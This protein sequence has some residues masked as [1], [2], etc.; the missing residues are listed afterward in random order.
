MWFSIL[1]GVICDANKTSFSHSVLPQ[2]CAVI[3]YIL[4]ALV[5]LGAFVERV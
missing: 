2:S 4:G 3:L 5:T 1:M